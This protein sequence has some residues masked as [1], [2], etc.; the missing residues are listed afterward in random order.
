[1]RMYHFTPA[2]YAMSDLEHGRLKIARIQELNDPFELLAPDTSDMEWRQCLSKLKSDATSLLGFLC[3]SRTW[4]NP[5]MWSHYADRHRGICLGFD[6]S[7]EH[8]QPVTYSKER[9]K[10]AP[11]CTRSGVE[12][13]QEKIIEWLQTKYDGWKYEDEIRVVCPLSHSCVE[14]GLYFSEFSEKLRLQEVILGIGCSVPFEA[15]RG[16]AKSMGHDLSISRAKLSDNTFDV[17]R[18]ESS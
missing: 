2:C 17:K 5:L 14:D 13:S 11:Q 3:F 18:A 16:A 1:M 6:V 9:P 12:L 10:I 8:C 7:D 4:K 15:I